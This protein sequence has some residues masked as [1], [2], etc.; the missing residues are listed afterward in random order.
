MPRYQGTY[1][2]SPA[3]VS[4]QNLFAQSVQAALAQ[5]ILPALQSII[6]TSETVLI[7]PL[8]SA[9]LLVVPIPPKV[10]LEQVAFDVNW[11]GYVKTTNA[12]NV[13]LKLY[14][15][16][17]ATV[18]NDTALA[19]TGAIAVTTTSCP[20]FLHLKGSY[21]S[22]SGKFQGYYDGQ[23]NGTVI[24]PTTFTAVP[25]GISD[26]GGTGNAPVLSF[27]ASITSSG[28]ASGTPTTI[29]TQNFAAA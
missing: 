2:P 11:S 7:S 22:V 25:T 20:F 5:G 8:N 10:G 16:T 9:N 3:P 17:S 4:G 28:A 21:D 19:T 13:T 29:N 27:L 24:S 6:A 23:L 18:G 12:G 26:A 14:S 15:G 1:G